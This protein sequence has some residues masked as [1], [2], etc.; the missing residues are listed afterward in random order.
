MFFD[1]CFHLLWVWFGHLLQ[2]ARIEDSRLFAEKY[3]D[4]F[5]KG[6]ELFIFSF[7]EDGW[8]RS[9]PIPSFVCGLVVFMVLFLFQLLLGWEK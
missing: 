4:G 1:I 2:K 6:F 3:V 5:G 8:F 9:V 7:C